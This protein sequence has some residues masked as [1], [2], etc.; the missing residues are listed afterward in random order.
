MTKVIPDK[1]GATVANV[2]YEKLILEHACPQILLCDNGKELTN[3][4]LACVCEQHYIEQHFTSPYVPQSNGKTENFNCFLKASI[5]KLCQD[6][7]A[8]WDQL[9]DQDLLAYVALTLQQVNLY[10]FWSITDP[11]PPIH[12]LIKAFES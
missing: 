4:L 10:S 9:T 6:D 5:R 8:W 7:M 1:E 12:Q 2:I 3:D 11:G